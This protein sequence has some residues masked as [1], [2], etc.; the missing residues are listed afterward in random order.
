MHVTTLNCLRF[1]TRAA[2]HAKSQEAA[3]CLRKTSATTRVVRGPTR[4]SWASTV[5]MGI[6]TSERLAMACAHSVWQELIDPCFEMYRDP[7]RSLKESCIVV[8]IFTPAERHILFRTVMFGQ[9]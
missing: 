7:K 5:G 9:S 3:T 6:G 1:G 4:G 2:K 8:S